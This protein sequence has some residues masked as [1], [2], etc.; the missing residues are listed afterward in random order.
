MVFVMLFHQM[1]SP[2]AIGF[3]LD[4]SD[5]TVNVFIVLDLCACCFLAIEVVLT[6]RTGCIIRQTNEIILNSKDIAKRYSKFLLPDVIGCI[7]FILLGT[8]IVEENHST[9]NGKLLIY[10]CCLFGFSFYRFSRILDYCSS[11]PI[12]LDLSEKGAII[13]ALCLRSIYW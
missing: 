12:I 10:M 11:I 4:M 6:F 7:P 5:S 1:I 9:I 3:L 13:F 8:K 2:M